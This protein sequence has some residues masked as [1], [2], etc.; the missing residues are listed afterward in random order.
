MTMAR[1]IAPGI[2]E[3]CGRRGVYRIERIDT[4]RPCE[5][6]WAITWPGEWRAD[7]EAATLRQAREFVARADIQHVT[8]QLRPI[9]GDIMTKTRATRVL[10]EGRYP[11]EE[12]FYLV[13]WALPEDE[14]RELAYGYARQKGGTVIRDRDGD[15]LILW[16]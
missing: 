8:P 16:G 3:V 12:P 10:R 1:R 9:R 5:T 2:Y 11:G 7:G 13:A 4:G 14:A 15:Y 6:F